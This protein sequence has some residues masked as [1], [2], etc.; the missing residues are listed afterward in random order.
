[1][2]VLELKRM[3]IKI[4]NSLDDLNSRLAITEK[5]VNRRQTNTN[6]PCWKVEKKKRLERNELSQTWDN[7]KQSNMH[8]TGDTELEESETGVEKY[9]KMQ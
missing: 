1:M 2:E 6:Y 3:K 8:I 4:K 7:I 9:L 5:S